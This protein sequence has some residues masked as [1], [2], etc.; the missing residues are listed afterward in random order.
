MLSLL[1]EDI[2]THS[3]NGQ[4]QQQKNEQGHS[5]PE[6]V[7]T[8]QTSSVNVEPLISKRKIPARSVSLSRTA[9][10]PPS[11][12]RRASPGWVQLTK[13]L[14]QPPLVMKTRTH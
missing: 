6:S 3:D 9:S 7:I 12:P 13:I 8:H 4:R 1:L 14:I 10:A 11:K 5:D 2:I